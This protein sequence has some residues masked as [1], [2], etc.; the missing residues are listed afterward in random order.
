MKRLLS[1]EIILS[2]VVLALAGLAPNLFPAA[3]A[4][5]AK[6][7]LLG[8]AV[9]LPSMALLAGATILAHNLGYQR[10]VNRTL[11]GAAAGILATL[12]LELVRASSFHFGGMPGDMPRLLGVL[13]TDRFMEGPSL[14]SDLLGWGYHFWNGAV[15]GIIFAVILGPRPLRWFEVYGFLIGFGFLVSPA[16]ASLGI[17]FLGLDMPAMPLTVILAHVAYSAVLGHLTNR[18]TQQ[19]GWLFALN[20]TEYSKAQPIVGAAYTVTVE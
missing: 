7:S 17:G 5:V 10:L 9:L 15:F 6:L 2:L 12:A 11:A 19:R 13:L 14:T 4:G 8:K 3:Q 18:W 16:V 20:Q 1:G